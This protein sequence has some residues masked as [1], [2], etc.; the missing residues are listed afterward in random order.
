MLRFRPI[1]W[2]L[3]MIASA[4]AAVAAPTGGPEGAA[5]ARA[6]A[7]FQR[8]QGGEPGEAALAGLALIKSDVPAGDPAV[9]AILG[10]LNQRF[11]SQTYK[12]ERTA[13]ADIYEAAVL[14]MFYA[15]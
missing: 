2:L 4:G 15:S 8:N 3:G 10:R 6:V 5:L 11:Q 1:A 9:Q 14:G 13:G 7:Y 12:P